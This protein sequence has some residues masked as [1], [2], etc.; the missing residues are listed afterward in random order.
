M[1]SSSSGFYIFSF[2]GY[3]YLIVKVK[4]TN[5]LLTSFSCGT[6]PSDPHIL[7]RWKLML[8]SW[9]ADGFYVVTVGDRTV[10]LHQGDVIVKGELVVVRVRYDL[11]QIPLL[12][13]TF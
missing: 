11:L 13:W 3:K 6:P 12:N 5:H 8:R 9:Q 4:V 10:Q 1:L 2:G 7:A